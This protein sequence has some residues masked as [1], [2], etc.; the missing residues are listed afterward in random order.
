MPPKQPSEDYE[1]DDEYVTDEGLEGEPTVHPSSAGP[2][3]KR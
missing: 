2:G 3:K 1:D